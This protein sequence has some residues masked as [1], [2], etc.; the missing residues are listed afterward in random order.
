MPFYKID[1]L[2]LWTGG[3]WHMPEGYTRK[4][5]IRGFSTDSRNIGTDYAFVALKGERD[6]CDFAADAVANG[7]TAVIAERRLDVPV[8]VLVVADSLKAFQSIAKFHRLRFENPVIGITGSCGKTSTKEMLAKL[9]AWKSPLVTEKNFN[10]EIGV[11]LTVT[12]IDLRQNQCA[13]VEAGVGAPNQMKELAEII[14]PD[15]AIITNVGLAHLERFG[16]IANVAKEKAVL[17]AH[18]ANGGWCLMHSNLLSWKSFEELKCRKAVVAKADSPDIKADLVFRYALS[19]TEN[20]VAI[21]M[22]VEGGREYFFEVGDMTDGM[23]ENAVLAIAAALMLGTKEEQIAAVAETFAPLPMRGLTVEVGGSKYYADCYNASPTSMKDA[24]AH[25][26]AK[27]TNE[28][29]RLFVLG[30]MAELGLAAHRHHKEIGY[31]LPY[32][33]GDRAVLIGEN[34]ET[35]KL[36]MT[37]SKWPESAIAVFANSADAKDAVSAFE[38]NVFVKGSRVCALEKLLPDAVLAALDAPVLTPEVQPEPEPEEEP[39]APAEPEE[40]D[41]DEEEFDE[42]ADAEEDFDGDE[43]DE[44]ETPAAEEDDDEDERETI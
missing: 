14:S 38:G 40:D 44:D 15:I 42:F 26:I 17:P 31:N 28:T 10:N 32:R 1:D 13:I 27:S 37:E 21:D 29:P 4:P 18:A 39:P 22:S 24:L 9:L 35:Y 7:A 36:G 3:T 19:A 33:E 41:E 25:F 43:D 34:A 30:S 2:R 5:D 8:P 11:P 16:E 6:G 20:G 23:V 12:K